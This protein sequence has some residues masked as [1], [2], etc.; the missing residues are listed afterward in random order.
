MTQT[1]PHRHL[2]LYAD[3]DGDDIDFVESAFSTTTDNVELVT[4]Q[5]GI[6]TI[7]FLEKLSTKDP[8]PCLIILDV[9]MPRLDGKETLRR[10]RQMERFKKVP[11]VLFTTSNMNDDKLFAERFNAGFVTKPLDSA[12]MRRITDQFIEYC[13]EDVKRDIRKRMN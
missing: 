2:V 13:T 3:D 10:I 9:N 7:E 12:Q 5:D 4:T 6:E 11:V 1:T 8:E